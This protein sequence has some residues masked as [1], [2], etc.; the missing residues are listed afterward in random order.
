M[1]DA[2]R[3][4][5]PARVEID[6]PRPD[7]SR[8]DGSRQIAFRSR[9]ANA[10]DEAPEVVQVAPVGP[11]RVRGRAFLDGEVAEERVDPLRHAT[12]VSAS[13]L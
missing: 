9:A 2:G 6:Q 1:R 10:R 5:Q 11:E 13:S 3:G 12:V 8:I 4:S 7:H